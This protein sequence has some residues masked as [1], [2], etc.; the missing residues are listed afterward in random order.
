MN[1]RTGLW[2]DV[3]QVRGEGYYAII[4]YDRIITNKQDEV[5]QE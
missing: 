4:K 2:D 3:K 1:I 5:A